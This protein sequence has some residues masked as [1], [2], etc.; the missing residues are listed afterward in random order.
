MTNEDCIICWDSFDIGVANSACKK[1]HIICLECYINCDLTSC[2]YC[3]TISENNMFFT[4]E[5]CI[6][7]TN[8]RDYIDYNLI[9]PSDNSIRDKITFIHL[10]DPVLIPLLIFSSIFN[11]ELAFLEYI[12]ICLLMVI[13]DQT[14]K[15]GGYISTVVMI[16]INTICIDVCIYCILE[17]RDIVSSFCWKSRFNRIN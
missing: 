16:I 5:K 8:D 15:I 13:D 3:R 4:N 2:C 7:I 10:K 9:Y 6:T 1:Q 12:N 14:T 17:I 11:I